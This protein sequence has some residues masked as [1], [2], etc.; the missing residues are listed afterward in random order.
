MGYAGKY[1]LAPNFIVEVTVDGNQIFAQATGQGQFELFAEDEIN[2][3]AKVAPI[4]VKI[5][6]N[7]SGEVESFTLYQG[8]SETV[9]KKIE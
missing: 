8:G 4:K 2:F 3:F 1:E 6:K 5:N 9:A 7:D